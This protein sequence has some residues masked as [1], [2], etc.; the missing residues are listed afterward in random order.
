MDQVV[1]KCKE[2]LPMIENYHNE[3]RDKYFQHLEIIKNFNL[4]ERLDLH[5]YYKDAESHFLA[6]NQELTA[7]K[8]RYGIELKKYHQFKKKFEQKPQMFLEKM[9]YSISRPFMETKLKN[10]ANR[11]VKEQQQLQKKTQQLLESDAAKKF[12]NQYV[13]SRQ[14]YDPA[15]FE[16][17]ELKRTERHYE[18][19]LKLISELKAVVSGRDPEK[20]I[21]IDNQLNKSSLSLQAPVII[22]QL[23]EFEIT[24]KELEQAVKVNLEKLGDLQQKGSEIER[25]YR[26]LNELSS[27]IVQQILDDKK[28][29]ILTKEAV[30]REQEKNYNQKKKDA[31]KNNLDK[32]T[33][34]LLLF[35]ADRL[36]KLEQELINDTQKF[37]MLQNECLK[38]LSQHQWNKLPEEIQLQ[39][40][41]KPSVQILREKSI[42]LQ[43]EKKVLTDLADTIVKVADKDRVVKVRGFYLNKDNLVNQNKQIQEQLRGIINNRGLR[44]QLDKD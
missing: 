16:Y 14:R 13:K 1:I 18:S 22:R 5:Q 28:S 15:V 27:Q 40:K 4:K 19:E 42:R 3:L 6:G 21:I 17:Q 34:E 43:N 38:Y 8:G 12:I 36:L 11:L 31:L 10:W 37:N 44:S 2:L 7:Q 35:E 30:Y 24:I 26:A 20:T 41:S 32:A 33:Q 9:A 29:L 25:N 23:S 39:L